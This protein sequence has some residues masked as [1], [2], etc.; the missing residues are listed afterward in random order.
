MSLGESWCFSSS[1][2]LLGLL[3]PRRWRHY[4]PLKHW[5]PLAQQHSV[6]MQK[7]WILGHRY[8]SS[9]NLEDAKLEKYE[10]GCLVWLCDVVEVRD[11]DHIYNKTA[12]SL[13]PQNT[14]FYR[15]APGGKHTNTG[16]PADSNSPSQTAL[17]HQHQWTW[18]RISILPDIFW[19]PLPVS[20][21]LALMWHT[22]PMRV[23]ISKN[24]LG[25]LIH[26]SHP[27]YLQLTEHPPTV[28]HY[29]YISSSYHFSIHLK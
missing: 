4:T 27:L 21:F 26:S 12:P 2:G 18:Y 10:V 28:L 17:F 13:Q 3:D 1:P 9:L 7:T 23:K 29:Y 16:H 24:G 8:V 22:Q 25:N 5:K 14:H 11:N 6:T 15:S 19:L 20:S